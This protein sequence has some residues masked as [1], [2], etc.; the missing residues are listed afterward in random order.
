M[1]QLIAVIFSFLLIPV[2]G[3]F[4]IKLSYT[5]L[6][7]ALMLGL[8][9]GIGAKSTL[10]SVISVFTSSSSI[11]TILT[12]LMVSIL[13][14]LM[15][16]YGILNK[17]V[18]TILLVVPDKR[19]ILIIIPALIGILI[20]PG[21]ALLSAPFI[22]SIGEEMNIQRQ[23]RAAINLVFRHIAMFI[24]PYSTGLLV[25][26]ASMPQIS[27]PKLV[28]LN[29]FYVVP[30]VAVGYYLYIRDIKVEKNSFSRHNLGKNL[31]Y[32]ALYTLP[33]YIC[34]I[35]NAVTGLP[36]YITMVSSIIVVYFLSSKQDFIKL[37]VKSINWH[38]VIMVAAILI[39]KEIILKMDDL[40]LVFNSMFNINSSII[41][42]MFIFLTASVFF[43]LVT[44]NQ[45]A[46]LAI[47]L[48]MISQL[49]VSEEMI[50]IY[51]YFSFNCAFV[52]YFFSPIHLCQA[53]TVQHMNITTIE[54]F[55]EYKYYIPLTLL[56]LFGSVYIMRIIFV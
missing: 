49:N 42:V 3:K 18:D 34:V 45:S 31:F 38:T 41:S 26:S 23:R 32:V 36:F 27:I 35:I 8:I 7:T 20:I 47:I 17:I 4:K 56:V 37:T 22:Y 24:L 55:K 52:G 25:I 2:L 5:L 14:G 6:I 51:L 48:P 43:G 30:M 21:G 16:H 15:K 10:S 11:N 19:I 39:M 40:L 53:F 46:A 33:I 50:Y 29:M 12:V 1:I 28:L 13:G 54:L 44:G 9:S